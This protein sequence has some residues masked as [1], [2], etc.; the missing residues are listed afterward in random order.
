MKSKILWLIALALMLT[1]A[2]AQDW[3]RGSMG[4]VEYNC[5]AIMGIISEVGAFYITSSW[6]RI[7]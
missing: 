4:N 2:G 3:Q 5:D 7:P 1:P 6:E